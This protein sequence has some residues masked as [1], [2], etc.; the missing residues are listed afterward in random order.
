[1]S[2]IS[3]RSTGSE[4]EAKRKPYSKPEVVVFG[5][6]EQVTLAAGGAGFDG[7]IGSQG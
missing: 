4:P 1:M 2:N 6:I 3:P 7:T 5:A